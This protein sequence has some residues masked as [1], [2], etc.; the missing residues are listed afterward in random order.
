LEKKKRDLQDRIKE[1]ELEYQNKFGIWERIRAS[2]Q[3]ACSEL[4]VSMRVRLIGLPLFVALVSRMCTLILWR[5]VLAI[6]LHQT[7]SQ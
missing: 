6:S 2:I 4:R 3:T 7:A 5:A 1:I